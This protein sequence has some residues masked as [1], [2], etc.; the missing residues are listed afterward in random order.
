[1]N[2]KLSFA[3]ILLSLAS[4]S[5]KA[6]PVEITSRSALDIFDPTILTPT[7]ST[8][9]T[10]GTVQSVTWDTSNAPVNISNGAEVF[11]RTANLVLAQGFDLRSGSVDITV[12]DVTPGSYQIILFGD[13][14]DVSPFFQI[15]A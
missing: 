12:P 4:V 6:S 13:S 10:I 11:L 5:V 8:V 1:M 7:A 2:F 9:W 15:V 14:G 3:T